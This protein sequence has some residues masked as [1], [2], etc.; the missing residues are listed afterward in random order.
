[1]LFLLHTNSIL[2]SI[3]ADPSEFHYDTNMTHQRRFLM[4]AAGIKRADAAAVQAGIPFEVLME[5]AGRAVAD[6]IRLEHSKPCRVLVVCG[7][8]NNGGDGFVI[9]RWLLAWEFNVTV[10]ALPGAGLNGAA[11]VMRQALLAWMPEQ[12]ILEITEDFTVLDQSLEHPFELIVDAIFGSGFRAPLADLESRLIE[13]LNQEK[14]TRGWKVWAVDVPS[15][16]LA[17][18]CGPPGLVLRADHTV[19]LS[20]MKATHLFAP[21]NESSGRIELAHVGIPAWIMLE[22]SSGELADATSLVLPSRSQNAHKGTAGRVIVAG[23]LPRYPGAPALAAHGAFR[24][25]AGLVTVIAPHGAGIRAPIESTRI[26]IGAWTRNELEFLRE[27][28]CDA[29]VA[30]MGMGAVDSDLLELLCELQ[31]PIV[32]DADALQTSLEPM[33]KTRWDR[34]G[35]ATPDVIM[36]PHPG[37]AARLLEVTTSTITSDPL[38]AVRA[39]AKRYHAVVVLKGGPTVIAQPNIDAEVHVWVNTTG[40]PGMASGGMGDVLGGVIAGLLAQ[41]LDAV[42]AARTGVYLHGRAGDLA[43]LEFGYGLSASDV[44]EHVPKAWLEITRP[45]SDKLAQSEDGL[46]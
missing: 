25:G 40:N 46:W 17:D 28:R 21:A 31:C 41:G 15:G 18:V 23:G 13:R 44:A 24:V 5:T 10:M 1:L 14:K 37:E 36:T 20:G 4:T 45:R 19:A 6:A 43:A 33:L 2:E 7:K 22:H 29:L 35:P 9:A 8:G 11:R 38:E 34:R 26:E 3:T 30:G 42:Q 16:I 12:T 27:E 39:L 32:L